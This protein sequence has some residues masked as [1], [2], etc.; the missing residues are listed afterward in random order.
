MLL[1][2]PVIATDYSGTTDFATRETTLLIDYEL[3]PVR[4]SEYPG[5]SGQ[6]WAEPDTEQA[7]AAM[8]RLSHNPDLAR[9]LGRASREL[10]CRLYDPEVVGIQ[11]VERIGEIRDSLTS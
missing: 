2:K 5:A 1:E 6:V 7:A 3:V 11:Y 8:R 4:A 10:I 9:R